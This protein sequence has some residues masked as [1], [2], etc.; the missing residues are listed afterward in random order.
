MDRQQ[1]SYQEV[2]DHIGLISQHSIIFADTVLNNL[3]LYRDL[4]V[5]LTQQLL[6]Q[7]GLDERFNDWDELIIEDGNLSGGQKQRMIIIRALL[8]NKKFII[9]DESLSALDKENYHRI[10]NYLLDQVDICL[11]NITH[12][13]SSNLSKYDQVLDLDQLI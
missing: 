1:V 10:E 4:P 5:E 3:H 2:Q 9:L 8:Q 6:E 11:I 13:D 12:R 7:F